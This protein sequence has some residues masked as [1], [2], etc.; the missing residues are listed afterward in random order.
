MT[1]EIVNL[2]Q[3][4]KNKKRRDKATEAAANRAAFGRSRAEKDRDADT[5]KRDDAFLNNRQ[6]DKDPDG[7]PAET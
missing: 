2:R 6:L 5:R 3:Y 1:A 7:S 4:R